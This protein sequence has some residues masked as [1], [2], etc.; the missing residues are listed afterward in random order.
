MRSV[1]TNV[2]QARLVLISVSMFDVFTNTVPNSQSRK[3]L[4]HN[5]VLT[6]QGPTKEAQT[7]G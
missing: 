1:G 7:L 5:C 4:C 3:R 2:A 6:V